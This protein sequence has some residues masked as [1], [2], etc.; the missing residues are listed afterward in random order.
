MASRTIYP[1]IVKDYE[2]AFTAGQNAKLRMYFN[3]S[4]LSKPL[5]DNFSVY[6][7]IIRKDGVQVVNLENDTTNNIYRATGIILNL[8]PHKISTGYYYVD[9]DNN[10]L[11]SDWTYDGTTYKGWIPG[12]SYKVQLRISEIACPSNR[13]NQQEA[14]LQEN[15]E[16]FSE[17]STICFVKCISPMEVINYNKGY[18]SAGGEP[19]VTTEDK[20]F[21]ASI[22]SIIPDTEDYYS[23]NLVL[24]EYDRVNDIDVLI[25][26]PIEYSGEIFN[27]EISNSAVKYTYKTNF[28]NGR[29]YSVYLN[30]ITENDYR[31]DTSIGYTFRYQESVEGNTKV[32]LLTVENL[33]E[34]VEI[35]ALIT[36]VSS[37]GIEEDEGRIGLKIY[38]DTEAE[39]SNVFTSF[40]IRRSSSKDNFTTWEDIKYITVDENTST[41]INQYPIVYDYTVES[42]IWYKYGIAG[43]TT[44][45]ERSNLNILNNPAIRLFE[46]SYIL[47]ENEKQLK[48]EF[49]NT[50]STFT[51]KVVDGQQE[52]IGSKYP[53]VG[54]NS[55]IDYKSFPITG[56]I[57]FW[58]DEA[59][60]FLKNGKEDIFHP[61]VVALYENYNLNRNIRQYDYTY[62]REFR[63]KVMEFLNDGK[64][65][66]FKSPSEGNIIVRLKDVNL[67]PNQPTGRLIY[68]F[69]A[70]ALEI[71]DDNMYNYLKYGFYYP[72]TY[73]T[74]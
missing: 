5:G 11:K 62:E 50:I 3:L 26:T 41:A 7:S 47:G 20:I 21:S 55:I 63:K 48:L 28:V 2:P 54:R 23:C 8:V 57:T 10:N 14:W 69:N 24:Y 34:N 9:I 42:G 4:S 36:N 73:R 39:G 67:T 43:V 33:T 17:W 15:S 68:S 45:G 72:G 25:G 16:L 52:P 53:F 19:T 46:Y 22:Q 74:Q 40:L 51:P 18:V 27:N 71:D 61:D 58:L 32:K 56:L 13:V 44:D 31:P 60:T 59:N 65:K 29:K 66:L 35:D 49:D 70:N 30:Y 1:P 37:L 12:W 64:P 38:Y 6:A